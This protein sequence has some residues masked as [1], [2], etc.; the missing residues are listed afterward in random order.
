MKNVVS[1]L[2]LSVCAGLLIAIGG[3]VFLS[4][5][6]RYIGAMLFSVALLC[7]CYRGYYLYTGKIGLCRH[8]A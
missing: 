4:C 1:T 7:I 6:N 8:R 5:E 2:R 3:S